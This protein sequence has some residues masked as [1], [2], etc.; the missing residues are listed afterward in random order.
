MIWLKMQHNCVSLAM[1][2]LSTLAM[3][4]LKH[5]SRVLTRLF[6]AT[7][8]YCKPGI[9]MWFIE[10]W[11]MMHAYICL[12]AHRNQTGPAAAGRPS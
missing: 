6:V 9:C 7:W 5:T 12:D 8:H 4:M 2:S 11:H 1:A 3:G 10:V